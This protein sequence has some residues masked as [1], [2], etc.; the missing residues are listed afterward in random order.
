MAL[1]FDF[2][3][4][5]TVVARWNDALE[6]VETP[7]MTNL[8]KTYSFTDN[9]EARVIPS[10]IHYSSDSA[11]T[12]GVQV[13]ANGLNTHPGTFRWLKMDLLRTGGGNRG[14]RVNG[15]HVYPRTAASELVDS[16]LLFVQGHFGQIDDEL[17][18]T[19]P[20]EAFDHYLD[21]LREA[22]VKRFPRGVHV[23]DEATACILGY[24][25]HIR[26]REVYCVIDFGGGTLDVSVVRTNLHGEG[27]CDVLGK[28]GE[29]IGGMLVD[30]WLLEH[31]QQEEGLTDEDIA[32][33]GTALLSKIEEAKIELSNGS[34]EVEIQQY[35]DLTGRLVSCRITADVFS[36]M[37]K[38][39]R[40]PNN[41]SL[42]QL[43]TRTLDL[44]L[45][46][47]NDKAGVRKKELKGV[48]M[49]GGSSMLLGV[50]EHVEEYFPDCKTFA[51]NPFEAIAHGACRYAGGSIN[52]ALVHDYCLRS[53]NRQSMDFDFVPVVSRGTQYPTEKPVSSKYLKAPQEAQEFLGMV[54]YERSVMERPEISYI[55]GPDGLQ[56][57]RKSVRQIE[58]EKALNPED[59]EFIHAVPPCNSGERRFVAGFG[60]DEHRRLT[61]WLRDLKEGNRSTIKLGDGTRIQLPVANLPVVKL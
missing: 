30:H 60:V 35:N 34:K 33:I 49:V 17:V 14:R 8:T 27:S 7:Y 3:T 61:L 12:I 19:V 1:A 53:W 51:G 26:D 37:L 11:K 42:Y 31:V 40:K 48:F 58:R 5:N 46:Q 16:I 41:N 29:E 21:W 55:N 4:C 43:I 52:Q 24:M 15:E 6:D 13:E 23:L 38:E 9:R 45:E 57:V 39:P 32:D 28:A 10:L 47:A 59:S 20:V 25:N 56:P 2:G 36:T 44:A 18:V 50:P 54:V 22:A